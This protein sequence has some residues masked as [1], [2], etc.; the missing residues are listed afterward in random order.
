MDG[1]QSGRKR[2]RDTMNYTALDSAFC[3]GNKRR[4]I[5]GWS[6]FS[7]GDDAAGASMPRY[8]AH[9]SLPLPLLSLS[10]SRI[11][12][13][14]GSF[15]AARNLWRFRYFDAFSADVGDKRRASS[16][17]EESKR[18]DL[19]GESYE[20]EGL[21]DARRGCEELHRMK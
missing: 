20:E 12:P 10:L 3:H 2:T 6:S 21:E 7:T 4:I 8:T 13:R 18:R 19:E 5:A 16:A 17:H 11:R 1:D 9:F 15:A 14:F